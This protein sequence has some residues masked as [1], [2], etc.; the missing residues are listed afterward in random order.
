[1]SLL[2]PSR[3]VAELGFEHPP[4]DVYL[5]SI[6]AGLLAAWPAMPPDSYAQRAGE[7]ALLRRSR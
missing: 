1:M 2:D 5:D 3:A 4:L 6:L 7:I